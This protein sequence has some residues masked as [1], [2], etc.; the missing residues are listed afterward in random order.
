M[1]KSARA[2]VPFCRTFVMRALTTPAVLA[3]LKDS[4]IHLLSLDT[5]CIPCSLNYF[6]IIF[7]YI[8]LI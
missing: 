4:T 7:I 2:H 1:T 3:D 6:A 8:S 5:G